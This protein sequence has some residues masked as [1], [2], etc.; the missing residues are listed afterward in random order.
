MKDEISELNGVEDDGEDIED[1]DE[2]DEDDNDDDD[3]E[4]VDDDD[5]EVRRGENNGGST[6]DRV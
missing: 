6:V 3:N 4:E 5:I 2:D 1:D